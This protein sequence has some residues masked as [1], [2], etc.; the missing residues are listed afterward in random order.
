MG[1]VLKGKFGPLLQVLISKF[2]EIHKI[3]KELEVSRAAD[4]KSKNLDRLVANNYH[5]NG[6]LILHGPD[7]VKTFYGSEGLLNFYS[8]TFSRKIF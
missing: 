8:T 1:R 3:L 2:S 7:G 4:L 5:P 6:I